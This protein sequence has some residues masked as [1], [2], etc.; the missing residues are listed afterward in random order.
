M[1]EAAK[2]IVPSGALPLVEQFIIDPSKFMV[3]IGKAGATI[4]EIIER[5]TV[6]I[7]LDRDNGI[8]K[9]SGDNKQNI[10]DACEHIKTISNNASPRKETKI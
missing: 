10:M 9:V 1:E 5:F 4:K 3:I 7:D 6:S 2:D 8:V